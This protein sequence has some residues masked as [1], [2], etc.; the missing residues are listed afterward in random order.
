[1]LV[2]SAKQILFIGPGKTFVL[3]TRQV[4]NNKES[5][6]L[7]SALNEYDVIGII[8]SSQVHP[9]PLHS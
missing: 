6:S 4:R 2:N 8:L 9:V 7:T 5:P 3:S 1:M